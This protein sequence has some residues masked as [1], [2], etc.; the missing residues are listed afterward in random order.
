LIDIE[1]VSFKSFNVIFMFFILAGSL[2][3]YFHMKNDETVFAWSNL[4]TGTEIV[5]DLIEKHI[6][7]FEL[8][9][10]E[11]KNIKNLEEYHKLNPLVNV[12]ALFEFE[13]QEHNQFK[14][15]S[16]FSLDEG[17]NTQTIDSILSENGITPLRLIGQSEKFS[18]DKQGYFVFA[19]SVSEK[20]SYVALLKIKEIKTLQKQG[21][22]FLLVNELGQVLT[23][24]FNQSI[25]PILPE[26]VD[27]I[28]SSLDQNGF[29]DLEY[30]SKKFL[31]S[32][33]KLT[34]EGL[35]VIGLI[36][37]NR[38]Y[39][40]SKHYF[41]RSTMVLLGFLFLFNAGFLLNRQ[42]LH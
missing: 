16:T 6:K 18:R 21:F 2:I 37:Q 32:F 15:I 11:N 5:T 12:N 38:I 1:Y 36:D 24:E 9:L 23:D 7:H 33:K 30:R 31:I 39:A 20:K 22:K 42:K 34:Y 14:L 29:L 19:K 41:L 35:I 26:F 8:Y 40:V 4:E 28:F 17:W 27:K 3:A 25:E 13:N 10:S